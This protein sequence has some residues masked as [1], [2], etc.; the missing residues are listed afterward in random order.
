M[1]EIRTLLSLPEAAGESDQTMKGLNRLLSTTE[2]GHHRG[3]GVSGTFLSSELCTIRGIVESGGVAKLYCEH[4]DGRAEFN[5]WPSATDG[6]RIRGMCLA[7]EVKPGSRRYE[8]VQLTAEGSSQER[9]AIK[10]RLVREVLTD[11]CGVRGVISAQLDR[12]DSSGIRALRACAFMAQDSCVMLNLPLP[13]RLPADSGA[14]AINVRPDLPELERRWQSLLRPLGCTLIP[15]AAA[16]TGSARTDAGVSRHAACVAATTT[17]GTVVGAISVRHPPGTEASVTRLRCDSPDTS[18]VVA[19]L[20]R[21]ALDWCQVEGVRLLTAKL[22]ASSEELIGAL[23]MLGF[24]PS[25]HQLRFAR[26]L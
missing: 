22:P 17:Q 5:E 19:A 1:V 24:T 8:V 18:T 13:A 26:R 3:A 14:S 12:T 9:D 6:V 23:S 25:A 15:P 16:T 20:V 7:Q 21:T 2:P 11:L 10:T 4:P